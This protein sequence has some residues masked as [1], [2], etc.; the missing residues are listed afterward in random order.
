LTSAPALATF[1]ATSS[2]SV[3]SGTS[4]TLTDTPTTL[5][6][7]TLEYISVQTTANFGVTTSS[8]AY[9]QFV[10]A[11]SATLNMT[12]APAGHPVI[13]T[14]HAL[15]PNSV[16]AIVFNYVQS[17]FSTTSYTGTT[18][19]VVAS[20]TLGAGS[21]TF[22]VPSGAATGAYVV[23]LVVSSQGAGGAPVGTGILDTPTTLTV[24]GVSGSCTNEGTACMG[25]S[26]TPAVSKQ[27]GNTIISA[28]YTN[29]SNAPQ[30][31]FIYAV[32]H[33]ALGQTVSYTTATISP[34]AG[35]SQTGQL[36]L[37]GLAPG[38]YSVTVFVVS[39]S[40]TA[41]STGT[42]VSVTI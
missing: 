30:T 16:Y 17:Q 22:N 26:G 38:T 32:V 28:S 21:A 41:L 9:A 40:G 1:T 37:F 29:N 10:L 18:V 34:A 13:L 5:E 19:G 36:V 11:S 12:S 24:G 42:T 39:S 15:N 20:N 33:N 35:A 25:I 23:D 6:T 31:A 4:I 3:P 27:S 8:D 7:G 14:A 2:G